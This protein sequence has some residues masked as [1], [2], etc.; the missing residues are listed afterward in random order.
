VSSTQ[1]KVGFSCQLQSLEREL[2]K[3]F[4]D[5]VEEDKA[6]LRNRFSTLIGT[7]SIY[8]SRSNSNWAAWFE[9]WL[10]CSWCIHGKSL[11][12]YSCA[13]LQS[14]GSNPKLSTSAFTS[15][16]HVYFHKASW[17]WIF[18]L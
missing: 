11:P 9:E 13:M 15:S 3:Y 4:P 18:F 6:F 8:R 7:A 14:N 5:L 16:N 10:S 2:Q 12:Q 1:L 17:S